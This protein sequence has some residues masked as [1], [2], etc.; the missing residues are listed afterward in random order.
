MTEASE[1]LLWEIHALIVGNGAV[2]PLNPSA[3]ES[4]A[5]ELIRGGLAGGTSSERVSGSRDGGLPSF[6]KADRLVR[7]K[8]KLYRSALANA[9]RELRTAA[10]LQ[11]WFLVPVDRPEPDPPCTNLGCEM[12]ITDL[13]RLECARCRQHR[14]RYKMAWPNKPAEVTT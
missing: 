10:L 3:V 5:S 4:K 6:D 1:K 11:T 13:G 9:V 8:R 14:S 2:V 7:Q 12:V